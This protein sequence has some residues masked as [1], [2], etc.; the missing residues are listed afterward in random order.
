MQTVKNT[1]NDAYLF[2]KNVQTIRES[3]QKPPKAPAR[4]VDAVKLSDI[5]EIPKSLPKL[6]HE[7]LVEHL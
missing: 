3:N 6:N 2:F 1:H 7:H 4:T 5:K